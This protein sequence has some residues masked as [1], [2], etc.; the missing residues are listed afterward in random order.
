MLVVAVQLP[1][2]LSDDARRVALELEPEASAGTV[3]ESTAQ[4]TNP[5]HLKRTTKHLCS[6]AWTT[7][8]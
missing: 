8:A 4:V 6:P 5:D 3:S 1:A 2:A 7:R